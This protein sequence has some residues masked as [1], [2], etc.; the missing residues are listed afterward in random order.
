MIQG[1][2]EEENYIFP[3]R[4]NENL[5]IIEVI[6]CLYTKQDWILK[7]ISLEM[8]LLDCKSRNV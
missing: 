4:Y 6:N 5:K 1:T 7:K 2:R 8:R 3:D